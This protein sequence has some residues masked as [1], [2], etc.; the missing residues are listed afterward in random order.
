MPRSAEASEGDVKRLAL[1]VGAWLRE[2]R[3]DLAGNI[4]RAATGFRPGRESD[5]SRKGRAC[6]LFLQLLRDAAASEPGCA[7]KLDAS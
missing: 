6:Q 1:L 4:E 2:T 5:G 3:T 7:G